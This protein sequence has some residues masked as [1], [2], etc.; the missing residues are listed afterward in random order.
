MPFNPTDRQQCSIYYKRDEKVRKLYQR[1][2]GLLVSKAIAAQYDSQT[3]ELL[4][5][6]KVGKSYAF[7]TGLTQPVHK[8]HEASYK[9][10]MLL[11]I[12]HHTIP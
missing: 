11:R 6:A 9:S 1:G 3:K 2:V 4:A 12:E 10:D 5:P 8:L 7:T